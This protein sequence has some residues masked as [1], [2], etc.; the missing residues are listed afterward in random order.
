VNSE[1]FL[2]ETGKEYDLTPQSPGHS[3]NDAT[4][5]RLYGGIAARY[6]VGEPGN[7][8]LVAGIGY[9]YEPLRVEDQ[10]NVRLEMHDAF[11]QRI[12]DAVHQSTGLE[13]SPGDLERVQY[14]EI[15]T[16]EPDLIERCK[17]FE[18]GWSA[19]K[20]PGKGVRDLTGAD[21]AQLFKRVGVGRTRRE[22]QDAE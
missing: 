19:L 12:V 8:D 16:A 4:K 11:V 13:I 3:T 7:S 10:E 20:P 17:A 22:D 2:D 18:Q 9:F 5:T 15:W 1:Q 21:I 14:L 6:W